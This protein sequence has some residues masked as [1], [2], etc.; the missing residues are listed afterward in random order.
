MKA[1]SLCCMSAERLLAW[2]LRDLEDGSALGIDEGLFFTPHEDDPFRMPRYGI[3][4]ETPVGVAAGPHTQLSQNIIAAWLTGAR[5]LELKTVQVLDD[6]ELT[7]PCIDMRDEGYNCEW[8]QELKLEQSY[9]EY[10]NAWVLVHILHDALGFPGQPG[11]LFNMSA[12]YDL[13]GI[14]SPSMQR[15]FSRMINARQDVE[16]LKTRLAGIYPRAAGLSIPGCVSNSLTISCMHGCPPEDV[17][18]IAL[19][20]I[21]N[22]R[23]HTTLKLNPTL[24]GAERLRGILNH[25]LGYA[26]DVPDAAFAHD[27]LYAD[28]LKIIATCRA[29][30][31][32]TGVNF[33]VKLTNTLGTTNT[34]QKL[35]KNET[36]LYMSGRALHP[37]AI[38]LAAMLQKD[39]DG[40]LDISFCAGVDAF[41]V[42][43]VLACGLAPATACSDLL[44]PGGY[45]RLSQYLLLLRERMRACGA[46]SLESLILNTAGGHDLAAARVR[47]LSVYAPTT[48]A[49]GNRYAKKPAPPDPKTSRPLPRFDCALAPCAVFCRAGHNI[50]VYLDHVA[51]GR[52]ATARESLDFEAPPDM[53]EKICHPKCKDRCAA[54]LRCRRGMYDTPVLV[55]DIKL[56][57]ATLP[58]SATPNE[59]PSPAPPWREH[60][61]AQARRDFGPLDHRLLPRLDPMFV[62][63]AEAAVLADA[64]RCLRCDVYCDICATVCPNRANVALPTRPMVLILEEAVRE[65]DGVRVAAVGEQRI[66][67][68]VQMVNIGDFCNECG[69]CA[70]FCPTAGA[71]YRDKARLHLSKNSFAAAR[72]GYHFFGSNILLGKHNG[73]TQRLEAVADMFLYEDEILRATLNRSTLRAHEVTLKNGARHAPLAPAQEMALM[74]VLLHNLSETGDAFL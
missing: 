69:N 4:L 63:L 7:K 61:V 11:V 41:N 6:L 74:Y 23:V 59:Q 24:L 57:V 33:G 39:F 26:I 27:I 5:Y 43:D 12:G 38:H 42:S 2:I 9:G 47:N 31:K 22:L 19:Y 73:L 34:T 55:R 13:A 30:A 20:F 40:Q 67:Q 36:M 28:A 62:P 66:T 54:Q 72:E 25:T 58:E 15:F 51:H 46:S 35:P 18:G 32:K 3:F 71:P 56:A 37:L 68:P 65:D 64:A 50:P 44:K 8:S 70:T 53:R 52:F 60:R 48:T 49:P 29:A 17:E 10:L 1:E 21:E 16:R 45:G 14:L